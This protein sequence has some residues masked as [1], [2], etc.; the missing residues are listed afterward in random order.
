MEEVEGYG[1][2][3]SRTCWARYVLLVTLRGQLG[4]FVIA[5]GIVVGPP[6]TPKGSWKDYLAAPD[7][8][9]P[10]AELAPKLEISG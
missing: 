4:S 10:L 2:M 7:S 9:V 1:R 3:C 5:S 6:F 8:N